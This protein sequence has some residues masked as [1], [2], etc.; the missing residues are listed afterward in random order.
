[1]AGWWAQ[2]PGQQYPD[3]DFSESEQY[4]IVDGP[5]IDGA[6]PPDLPIEGQATYTGPAGGLYAY[7][8]ERTKAPACS[9]S[10]RERS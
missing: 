9:P 10:T 3:L 4:A 1:M 7:V 5:G 6:F 2:F 8:R